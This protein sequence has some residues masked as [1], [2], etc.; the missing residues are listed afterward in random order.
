MVQWITITP[1]LRLVFSPKRKDSSRQLEIKCV[2]RIFQPTPC[3]Q[4]SIDKTSG[5]IKAQ[6]D[7]NPLT[8]TNIKS[9]LASIHKE[10]KINIKPLHHKEVH[11]NTC[12]HKDLVN[13]LF[14]VTNC[15]LSLLF[16]F[17]SWLKDFSKRIAHTSCQNI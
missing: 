10:V 8:S 17:F 12:F 15:F 6:L 1:I 4:I 3:K 16:I 5:K 9:S 11:V 14:L 7:T 13:S 2:K